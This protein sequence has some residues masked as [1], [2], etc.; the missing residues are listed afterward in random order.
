M[1]EEESAPSA[2]DIIEEPATTEAPVIKLYAKPRTR[3]IRP[4]WLLEEIG[5]AYELINVED[6]DSPDYR[7]IHPLGKVPALDNDGA[8]MFES[9]AICMVLADQH[10]DFGLA[11]PLVAPERAAYTQWM[12]FTP[13]TLEPALI[14]TFTAEGDEAKAKA[15][16]QLA[17][18]LG[19][20]EKALADGGP[21]LL[22]ESFSAADILLGSVMVWVLTQ[23][24][25]E[26][27]PALQTYAMR[28]MERDAFQRA[29]AD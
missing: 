6:A 29:S 13:G 8:V 2:D 15:Q 20:V 25:L 22:G 7:A 17:E 9:A 24:V 26:K 12:F 27:F 14:G 4:R 3:S 21:Y 19:V 1:S 23:G 10:D 11:P 28:L 5:L 16:A 18:V